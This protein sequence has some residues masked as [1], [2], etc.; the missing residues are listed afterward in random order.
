MSEAPEKREAAPVEL[1]T[2]VV[3]SSPHLRAPDS[4][5]QIMW[6]VV[7]AL[8]PAFCAAV[9]VFGID[10]ARVTLLAVAAAVAT[11]AACQALRRERVT[12][13]DGSA[14]VTGVLLAFVLPADVSWYVPVVGS[15]V[16]IAVAKQAFGGLGCNFFNPAL[17]GRA[18]L[19]FAFADQVTLAKWRF[20][21]AHAFSD[22]LG[23]GVDAVSQAT[24]LAVLKG[25]PGPAGLDALYRQYGLGDLVL[26][27]VPGSIGEVSAFALLLGGLILVANRCINWR[28]P[29]AMIATVAIS[30]LL[31]PVREG[32][33]FTGGFVSI[34]HGGAL[35]QGKLALYH[36]FAGGLFLGAFFMATDM[37]TSP[38]TARGQIVFGVGAGLLVALIR[39]YGGYPEG[40]CYAILLMNAARPLID[41]YTRPRVFG[42]KRRK[43]AERA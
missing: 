39:L 41:R 18:F 14:V 26:G 43:E 24:P 10:A 4:I 29:A 5:G 31:L 17:I 38:I 3:S 16:A 6:T 25:A 34:L 15:I 33:A 28:L 40:V 22:L 13:S 23:S 32:G 30:V 2:L 27:N 35:A 36:L 9:Y 42:T 8:L 11:E 37:V 19:Q 1:G 12:V 21:P 20:L 7:L